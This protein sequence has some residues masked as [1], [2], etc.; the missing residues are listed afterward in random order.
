ML[1]NRARTIFLFGVSSW[2]P[3]LGSGSRT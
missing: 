1:G 2:P 3:T